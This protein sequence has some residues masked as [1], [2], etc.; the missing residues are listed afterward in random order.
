MSIFRGVALVFVKGICCYLL[1]CAIECIRIWR[2]IH[3]FQLVVFAIEAQCF[4]QNRGMD[5]FFRKET[6]SDERRTN[7]QRK[8]KPG[9]LGYCW[10]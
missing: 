6:Q 2:Y 4:N 3:V 9:C 7:E 5:D 1:C 10:G 8:Q